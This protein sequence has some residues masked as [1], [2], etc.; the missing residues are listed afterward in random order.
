MGYL[1]Q[2]PA[3]ASSREE[4]GAGIG[5]TIDRTWREP[6][7]KHHHRRRPGNGD[8]TK[9]PVLWILWAATR[10]FV[11]VSEPAASGLTT[12]GESP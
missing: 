1:I 6:E 12:Q 2:V 5:F 8:L 3:P 7:Q 4:A 10:W 9:Y 11:V